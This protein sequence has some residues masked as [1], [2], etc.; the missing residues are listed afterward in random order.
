MNLTFV[1]P[2]IVRMRQGWY[3]RAHYYYY[4]A[5][6][7]LFKDII[8]TLTN[9]GIDAGFAPIGGKDAGVVLA[10]GAAILRLKMV[11]FWSFLAL[12]CTL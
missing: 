2:N 7:F 10:N 5:W 9:V 3:K 4:Y 12:P 6:D 11:A 1:G 8:S